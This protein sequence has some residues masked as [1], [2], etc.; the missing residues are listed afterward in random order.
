MENDLHAMAAGPAALLAHAGFPGAARRGQGTP[1][2]GELNQL[3]MPRPESTY[4]FRITGH[5]WADRGLT[6]GDIAVVDRS[7]Q[8]AQTDLVISW[9]DS[10]FAIA[11]R[12]QLDPGDE[13]LGVV[14]AVIHPLQ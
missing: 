7:L 8:P 5:S 9:H 2:K 11:K 13:P 6:D 12:Y 14:T 1:L 10:G 3:L 4:L